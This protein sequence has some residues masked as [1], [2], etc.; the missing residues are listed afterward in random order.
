MLICCETS[1]ELPEQG[2]SKYLGQVLGWS[3]PSPWSEPAGNWLSLAG[4]TMRRA[5]WCVWAS[6]SER[7]DDE[8]EQMSWAHN[9]I[10]LRTS[11]TSVLWQGELLILMRWGGDTVVVGCDFHAFS[12]MYVGL[13]TMRNWGRDAG[14]QKHS[15]IPSLLHLSPGSES[16]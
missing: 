4:L 16:Y 13:I 15:A 5:W 2:M 10:P 7:K 12:Q 11:V 3:F 9:F 6:V 8:N 14:S 1:W